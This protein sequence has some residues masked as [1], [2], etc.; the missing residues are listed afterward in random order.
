LPLSGSFRLLLAQVKLELEQLTARIEQLDVVI[1]QRAKE[2][3]VCQRLTT[4]PGVGPVRATALIAAV[5]NG[6]T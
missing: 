2:D 3:E 6:V 1:L 5:G 4:I